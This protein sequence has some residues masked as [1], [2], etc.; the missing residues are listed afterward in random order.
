MQTGDIIQRPAAVLKPD[1]QV[2]GRYRVTAQDIRSHAL[3][4]P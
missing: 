4:D 3:Q 1:K 2:E